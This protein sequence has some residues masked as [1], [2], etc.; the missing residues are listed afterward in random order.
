LFCRGCRG[1]SGKETN[2]PDRFEISV[3]GEQDQE[4]PWTF[5]KIHI[6]YQVGGKNLTEKAISQAIQLS[7]EKYCSVAATIRATAKSPATLKSL[8]KYPIPHQHKTKSYQSSL[9]VNKQ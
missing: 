2:G 1:N 4:P 5:R 7:Q 6:H 8:S 3:S 9:E